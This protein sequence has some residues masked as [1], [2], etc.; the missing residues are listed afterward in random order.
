MQSL[1]HTRMTDRDD[2]LLS[3]DGITPEVLQKWAKQQLT[4][5]QDGEAAVPAQS[6]ND[7]DD[8]EEEKGDDGEK[9]PCPCVDSVHPPPS[10]DHE[11]LWTELELE[12]QQQLCQQ[13]TCW[14]DLPPPA[15]PLSPSPAPRDR[16][17]PNPVEDDE[18]DGDCTLLFL[19]NELLYLF[20]SLKVEES[21]KELSDFFT[22]LTTPIFAE[23]FKALTSRIEWY[24]TLPVQ[25]MEH[26]NAVLKPKP[27]KAKASINTLGP[28]AKTTPNYELLLRTFEGNYVR[29][30]NRRD[31]SKKRREQKKP[32]KT[33]PKAKRAA[34]ATASPPAKAAHI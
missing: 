13:P 20:V 18:G 10:A 3:E 21:H 1:Y 11:P 22:R 16:L 8:E 32:A 23:L 6:P 25:A 5:R 7:D 31:A 28:K 4:P 12:Q 27:S 9:P 14:G 34:S 2:A 15:A 24:K 19:K 33:K 30:R 29:A 26:A 17:Q